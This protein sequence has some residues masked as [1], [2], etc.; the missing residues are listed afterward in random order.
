VDGAAISSVWA[1][2]LGHMDKAETS[3]NALASHG[4][5]RARVRGNIKTS[6]DWFR[7][8]AAADGMACASGNYEA[9]DANN[10]WSN[11]NIALSES[12]SAVDFV[13]GRRG[14]LTMVDDYSINEE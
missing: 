8:R 13:W 4:R 2:L 10:L 11:L 1:V 12:P 14:R 7:Q 9:K 3:R 6:W 5:R